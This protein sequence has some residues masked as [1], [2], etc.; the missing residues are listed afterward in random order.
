MSA[1]E[2][3]PSRRLTL[4]FP[5]GVPELLQFGEV[6]IQNEHLGET[7]CG[8]IL[9]TLSSLGRGA[10]GARARHSHP[11]APRRSRALAH[12]VPGDPNALTAARR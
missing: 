4:Q 8:H 12:R 10:V 2:T 6:F 1:R 11:P 9:P 5:L 7:Q 3:P